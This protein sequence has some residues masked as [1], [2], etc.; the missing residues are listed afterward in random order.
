M[1]KKL[2]FFILTL[3]FLSGF[4]PGIIKLNVLKAQENRSHPYLYYTSAD[5][6]GLM[7]AA[8]TTHKQYFGYLKKWADKFIG[9]NPLPADS[10]PANIDI[11]QVYCESGMSYIFNMALSYHLTGE[12][13]YLIAAKKWLL[14]FGTY[15]S[16]IKGNFCIGAYAVAV[17]SGYDMLYNEL[18]IEERIQLSQHLAAIIQ[19]GVKGTTS[20]WWAGIALNHDHWLPVTGLG[21]GAAALYYENP[22]AAKWLGYLLDILKKDMNIAGDDGAWT[23]GTADWVY[24][25]S[26]TYVFFDVY[27]RL[28][29]ENMFQLPMVK[30]AIDYRLYNWLTDDTYIYHHDSFVNGRYNVLGAVSSHLLHK[31]ALENKDGYIQ[32]L[33]SRD[34]IL[35]MNFLTQDRTI[36]NDWHLSKASLVPPTYCVGWNYLW[37]DPAV[38]AKPPDNLPG[39]RYFPNQELVIMRTGWQTKDVVFAFTCSPVGGHNARNSV[40][41]G[42]KKILENFGHTHAQANSFDLYGMGNYLAVPPSYGLLESKSHNTLTIEGAGQQRN[43]VHDAGLL[44][45]DL[46]SEYAYL[47]GDATKCY[48]ASIGL[49]RWYRHVAFLPPDNFVMVDELRLS[50]ISNT[51]LTTSWHLN[52]LPEAKMTIDSMRQT[53]KINNK[54]ILNARILYPVPSNYE[55]KKLSW[56]ARQVSVRFNKLFATSRENQIVSVLSVLENS[57]GTSPVLRLIKAENVAG[58]VVDNGSSSRAAVICINTGSET[59][60]LRLN[61][62]ILAVPGTKCYLFFLQPRT[63][64]DVGISSGKARNGLSV[65]TISIKE[66]I[67]LTTNNEGTLIFRLDE[68]NEQ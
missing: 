58:A 1:S 53:I 29:G 3:I 54:S 40:L 47:A 12:I 16:D 44:M 14:A 42:N 2:I 62:D 21:V 31:L 5:I 15:P 35:D 20:D 32:W 65:Y 4:Y 46:N 59:G 55:D 22:E 9:F 18:S 67:G 37:Y 64:Y 7:Q 36:N 33:A 19:R 26:L 30:N 60:P 66:G 11:M 25:M 43:P 17:A 57:S 8:A 27:K 56:A 49:E 10:L 48:P 23:E 24:A 6:P 28:S 68:M 13:N 39:Y 63:T 52:Y 38:A 61:F 41:A 45:T 34:E 51:D 50:R